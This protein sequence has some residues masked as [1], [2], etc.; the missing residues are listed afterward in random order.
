[1]ARVSIDE[2]NKFSFPHEVQMSRESEVDKLVFG[3]LCVVAAAAAVVVV[4][5]ATAAIK[6]VEQ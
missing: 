1:M 6:F 3:G 2:Y 4:V 5:A